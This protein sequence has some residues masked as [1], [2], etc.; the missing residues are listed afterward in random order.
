MHDTHVLAQHRDPHCRAT[1][2]EIAAALTGHYRDEHVFVLTQNLDLFDMC[3]TQ[4]AAC[5]ITIEAQLETLTAT[6]EAPPHRAA[7]PAGH[8]SPRE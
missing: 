5:D 3:Q 7:S 8:P 1:T 4:L 6:A 2:A